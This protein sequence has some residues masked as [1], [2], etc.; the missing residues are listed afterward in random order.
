M[1]ESQRLK[2]VETRD[3]KQAAID[4]AEQTMRIYRKAVLSSR[5]RGYEKPHH[6]SLPGYRRGF[7]ES[8]CALKAYLAANTKLTGAAPAGD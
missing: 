6:A 3:G 1:P 8:Y 7:I 5:K 4:F 2:F